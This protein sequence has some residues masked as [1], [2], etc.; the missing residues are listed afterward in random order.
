MTKKHVESAIQRAFIKWIDQ[1]FLPILAEKRPDISDFSINAV[2]NEASSSA[3]SI[4]LDKKMGLRPGFPD[5]FVL[6]T[7][8]NIR[9][10]Y[11]L[12]MKTKSG[13]LSNSQQV[14]FGKFKECNNSRAA[15]AK[16]FQAA[17]DIMC[18][19]FNLD[20]QLFQQNPDSE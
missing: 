20:K 9:H 5:L 2:R 14:W 8:D 3:M 4:A 16:G 19:W 6:F 1:C 18:D 11:F 12:E 17:R 13:Y 7:I 10:V 15:V